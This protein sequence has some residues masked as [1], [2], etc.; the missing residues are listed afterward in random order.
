MFVYCTCSLVPVCTRILFPQESVLIH[1]SLTCFYECFFHCTCSLAP[2]WK[3][4]N[5][6]SPGKWLGWWFLISLFYLSVLISNAD[7]SDS[8]SQEFL[9]L[10]TRWSFHEVWGG[11]K[12]LVMWLSGDHIYVHS[13]NLLPVA[14]VL[15]APYRLLMTAS[16]VQL[17]KK[18]KKKHSTCDCPM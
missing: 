1:S 10:P 5:L 15:F 8:F 7:S 9:A 14:C 12:A 4:K 17:G 16:S 13:L 11:E 18:K 2:V 6:T 3:T